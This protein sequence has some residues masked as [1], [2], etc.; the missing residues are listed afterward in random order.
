VRF[1]SLASTW[2][3]RTSNLGTLGTLG[4]SLV[5]SLRASEYYRRSRG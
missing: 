2:Q 4:T 5:A 1:P 3:N